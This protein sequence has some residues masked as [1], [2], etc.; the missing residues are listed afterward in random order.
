MMPGTPAMGM[1]FYQELAP[2][3]AMDRAEIVSLTGQAATRGGTFERCVKTRGD[4][5][6]REA[7]PR[8]RSTHPEPP[9]YD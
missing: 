5:A 2:G 4:H 9:V 6:A 7:G 8:A 1:R 3:I